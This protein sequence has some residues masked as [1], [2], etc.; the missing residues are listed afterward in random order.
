[1]R[2]LGISNSC[3]LFKCIKITKPPKFV[4]FL[5]T[6]LSCPEYSQSKTTF[7]F[8]I[9]ACAYEDLTQP[10]LTLCN[11]IVTLCILISERPFLTNKNVDMISQWYLILQRAKIFTTFTNNT[12]ANMNCDI[13]MPERRF[14]ERVVVFQ[15]ALH[16]NRVI[17][18]AVR[19]RRA[20][21]EAWKRA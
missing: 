10:N 17:S 16:W 11:I 13:L 2:F 14:A 1:M 9:H 7:T 12:Q 18:I 8:S 19:D 5:L 20:L 3:L 15:R 6:I 21:Y 4:Y